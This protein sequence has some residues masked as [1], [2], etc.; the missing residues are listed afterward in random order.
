VALVKAIAP[1]ADGGAT[2]Q[3]ASATTS[4]NGAATP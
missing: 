4:S 2:V 3:A 1:G